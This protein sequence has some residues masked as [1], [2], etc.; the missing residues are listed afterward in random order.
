MTIKGYVNEVH[1]YHESE[2]V[3]TFNHIY[4][5][6]KTE[7]HLEHY[8]NLSKRKPRAASQAKPVRQNVAKE[9]LD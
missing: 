3:T 1:I 6:G 8:I 2:L 4:G 5:S 9:L 7:Y